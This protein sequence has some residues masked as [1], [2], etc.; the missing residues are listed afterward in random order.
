MNPRPFEVVGPET[1]EPAAAPP[2]QLVTQM[3]TIA[4]TALSQRALT[5]LASLFSI[6]LAASAFVLWYMIL[7]NPS[8]NQLVGLGMYAAFILALHVIR[9]RGGK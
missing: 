3:L 9:N 7:P 8:P 5:A 6:V 1:D 4:L 2:P